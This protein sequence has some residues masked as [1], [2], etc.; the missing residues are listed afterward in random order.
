MKITGILLAAGQSS[1]FGC[2]K[3]TYELTNGLLIGQAALE[4]IRSI[5]DNLI[6]V[7]PPDKSSLQK[8]FHLMIPKPLYA[9]TLT[10]VWVQAWLLA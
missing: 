10:K 6:V 3:L 9:P 8:L 7:V 4:S 5:A 1:R 2:N